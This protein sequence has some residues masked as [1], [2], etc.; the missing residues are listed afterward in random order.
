MLGCSA[1]C[2]HIKNEWWPIMKVQNISAVLVVFPHLRLLLRTDSHH[3]DLLYYIIYCIKTLYMG[4]RSKI[5]AIK[6]YYPKA[7]FNTVPFKLTTS[8][9][10]VWIFYNI[11]LPQCLSFLIFLWFSF[12]SPLCR[13]SGG[14]PP[15]LVNA[16]TVF[17]DV[18]STNNEKSFSRLI[19]R[20]KYFIDEKILAADYWIIHIANYLS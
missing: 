14:I 9:K 19:P 3:I 1:S 7:I 12:I 4:T 8:K 10:A 18:G 13:L 6:L 2:T 17:I 20:V 11:F 5:S 15:F 16:F